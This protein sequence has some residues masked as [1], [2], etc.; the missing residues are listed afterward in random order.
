MKAKT[1]SD[2]IPL[3]SSSLPKLNDQWKKKQAWLGIALTQPNDFSLLLNAGEVLHFDKNKVFSLFAILGNTDFL[4]TYT[5]QHNAHDV[6]EMIQ[7]KQ[8][9]P[10]RKGAEHGHTD[11]LNYLEAQVSNLTKE[12][13]SADDYAAY[14]NAATNG[15]LHILNALEQKASELVL[16]MIQAQSYYSFRFAAS[17]GHL[18]VLKHLKS[19]APQ[20]FNEMIEAENFSAYRKAFENKVP[21]VNNWLLAN[22]ST[23]F[24]YAEAHMHEYG[25]SSVN[26][27]IDQHIA[28]LRREALNMVHGVFDIRN[29]ESQKICFYILRN[30]IRRNDRSLDDEIRFLLSIPSVKSLAHRE[31]T[32]GQP[33]ELLRL[34]LTTNNQEAATL[35]INIE[36]VRNLAQHHDFYRAEINGQLNLEQ[37]SQDRE[38]SMTALTTGEKK[39][40][41][42]AINR[43]EPQL[44][45]L[46]TNPTVDELRTQLTK[47][48]NLNQASIIDAQGKHIILPMSFSEFQ[49]INLNANDRELALKAYYKNKDHSAWRYL[50]KP[51]PWMHKEAEYVHKDPETSAQWSTF[52]EYKPLI[53]TLWLAA[54][55]KEIQPTDGHTFESRVDHFVDELALLGRAHNWNKTRINSK[56]KKEEFDDLEGDRP[57]CYSG[58]KRRLFQSVLGHPLIL[59]LTDDTLLEELRAFARDHFQSCI[60]DEKKGALRTAF[61]DYIVNTE[62]VS[63]PNKALLASLNISNNKQNEFQL[64]LINKYGAQY[65]EDFSFTKLMR[66][67]LELSEANFFDSC[68]ALMLDGTVGLY[69]MLAPIVD[70]TTEVIVS[71]KTCVSQLGFFSN[72]FTAEEI[73]PSNPPSPDVKTK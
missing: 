15:H 30:L 14:K 34:A 73:A 56:G 47:R 13:I 65:S 69:D 10:Y 67:K 63:I 25:A 46:G 54:N 66:N 23:C 9:Y 44:K 19:K 22:S 60:D 21:A 27:F 12:M 32:V 52:E 61:D 62:E 40:F 50:S 6:L 49:K 37:L 35:L 58:V 64:Y 43:Y 39:R 29:L 42:A 55:D 2:V 24:A 28:H 45:E 68:H 48:Y 72:P 53:A 1:T 57:S 51:N 20:L 7:D 71:D 3:L 36:A 16:K 31:L 33:N 41:E 18:E 26:P 5:K 38:S 8:F 59:I 70:S 17:N 4:D 11:I